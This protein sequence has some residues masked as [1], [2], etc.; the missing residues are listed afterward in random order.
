MES[1]E[2]FKVLKLIEI[3]NGDPLVGITQLV[4]GTILWDLFLRKFI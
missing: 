2:H 4:L 3:L 1:K